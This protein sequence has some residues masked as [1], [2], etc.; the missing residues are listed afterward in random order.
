M[1]GLAWADLPKP[2]PAPAPEK[3]L[4]NCFFEKP[5]EVGDM[6][7]VAA[8]RKGIPYIMV[9][10]FSKETVKNYD[11]R[12]GKMNP[13]ILLAY[14]WKG[15]GQMPPFPT[16]YFINRNGDGQMD[17][18]WDDMMGNGRCDQMRQ[19]PIVTHDDKEM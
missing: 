3:A 14:P 1:S 6:Y 12:S 18:E 5:F 15:Y 7:S 17:E 9:Y 13:D 8:E 16:V 19:V 10:L 2:K 11:Q 4:I